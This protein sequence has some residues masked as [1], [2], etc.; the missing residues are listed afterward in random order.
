MGYVEGAIPSRGAQVIPQLGDAAIAMAQ[1]H[2]LWRDGLWIRTGLFNSDYQTNTVI[3][4][5]DGAHQA[6]LLPL[7]KELHSAGWQWSQQS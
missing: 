6:Q 1:N 7:G 2:Q 3:S 4:G 5:S